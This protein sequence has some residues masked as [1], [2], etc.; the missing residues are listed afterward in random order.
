MKSIA[1]LTLVLYS[2]LI[3]AQY[4]EVEEK[5]ILKKNSIGVG[6][7]PMLALMLGAS[8]EN[9]HYSLNYR[10]L[11]NEN[12]RLR[13][14]VNYQWGMDYYFDNLP[15]GGTDST[16][17][18]K[19]GNFGYQYAEL[20][21]GMEWSDF[22]SKHDG[23]YGFDVL[24]GYDKYYDL[25]THEERFTVNNA[26]GFIRI[27]S[28]AGLDTV[29]YYT[30]HSFAIGLAPFFGYRVEMNEHW[31]LLAWMSPE[32]AYVI[33][34]KTDTHGIQ[35]YYHANSTINFRLRLLDVVVGYRF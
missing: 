30:N 9:L 14:I 28:L 18:M 10:R 3:N 33:P 21:V 5:P 24:V 11:L 35:Q 8:A 2:F 31:E 1:F 22:K 16:I 7:N 19:G 23:F 29:T 32:F 4:L 34:V 12:R 17:V 20:K 26:Y 15:V 13:T 25:Q 27:G 6:L